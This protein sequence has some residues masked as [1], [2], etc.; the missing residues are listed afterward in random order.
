MGKLSLDNLF[1]IIL[2]EPSIIL[3]LG[4]R[5]SGKTFASTY[6]LEEMAEEGWRNILFDI[7]GE[8]RGIHK[9]NV[10]F[11]MLL[12]KYGLEPRGYEADF[13]TFKWPDGM[14]IVPEHYILAPIS[15]KM[16]YPEDL[17]ML[18]PS[19]ELV[20]VKMLG[21]AIAAAGGP[22]KATME[23]VIQELAYMSHKVSYRLLRFLANGIIDDTSPLEP[24]RLLKS[25][26]QFTV[27]SSGFAGIRNLPVQLWGLREVAFSILDYVATTPIYERFMI[28]FREIS[29]IAP[30]SGGKRAQWHTV[31][32]L[33]NMIL[34]FRELGGTQ[35]R[36][37]VEAQYSRLIPSFF[38]S[39]ARLIFVSP[40]ILR[41]DREVRDI[42]K[43]F[44]EI[45][46]GVFRA[47]RK[48]SSIFEPGY[49]FALTKEGSYA[50]MD[51]PPCRSFRPPQAKTKE[52]QQRIRK[53]VEMTIPMR[54]LD[55]EILDVEAKF[56][57]LR[58][59]IKGEEAIMPTPTNKEPKVRLDA[60]VVYKL[61]LYL[62]LPVYFSYMAAGLELDGNSFLIWR[63]DVVELASPFGKAVVDHLGRGRVEMM[64]RAAKNRRFLRNIGFI[65]HKKDGD[66]LFELTP[67]FLEVY[68]PKLAEIIST[69]GGI[70]EILRRRGLKLVGKV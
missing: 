47:L 16:I 54:A 45:P 31:D 12:Q 60:Q 70:E 63:K 33:K 62:L 44:A 15:L 41:I 37:G 19:V 30:R 10:F 68:G 56:I 13:Y 26:K 14:N 46:D 23:G 59:V 3:F 18:M 69:E 34:S 53:I 24:L 61:P 51:M 9:P 27:I 1:D 35:T 67:R 8:D 58:R 4:P 38:L 40:H 57:E 49:F 25:E 2:E 42:E 5:G 17:K 48:S 20:D 28:W 22:R 43:H 6:F 36:I 39:Q 52:E 29:P 64:L 65:I 32:L 11:A 7:R 55:T 21:E 66:Y 50:L